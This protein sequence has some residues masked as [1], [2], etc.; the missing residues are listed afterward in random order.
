M[1]QPNLTKGPIPNELISPPDMVSLLSEML[2]HCPY[3]RSFAWQPIMSGCELS[4]EVVFGFL[5][6]L[7]EV[8]RLTTRVPAE[9]FLPPTNPISTWEGKLSALDTIREEDEDEKELIARSPTAESRSSAVTSGGNAHEP[10]E[11][12]RIHKIYVLTVLYVF[13][14]D[15]S[16]EKT[17][18]E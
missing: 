1:P 16:N 15:R 10:N 4:L 13:S 9:P 12:C 17:Q 3:V 11:V 7:S 2:D 18:G 14:P 6:R 5:P 8:R